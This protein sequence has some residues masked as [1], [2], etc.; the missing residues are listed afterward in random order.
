MVIRGVKT[1]LDL[2]PITPMPA[3]NGRS[4]ARWYLKIRHMDT[5]RERPDGLIESVV[6]KMDSFRWRQTAGRNGR[7]A[8]GQGSSG[9][10]GRDTG[11]W[12]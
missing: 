3:E 1:M 2:S 11:D 6:A 10:L 9:S 7:G 4:A 8:R 12:D 5:H